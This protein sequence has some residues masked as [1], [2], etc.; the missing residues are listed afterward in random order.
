MEA[1]T[2]L[3]SAS[4][5]LAADS[6]LRMSARSKRAVLRSV[7]DRISVISMHLANDVYTFLLIYIH[8]AGS[9]KAYGQVR[10]CALTSDSGTAIAASR[11]P[12]P[13][14]PHPRESSRFRPSACAPASL[15]KR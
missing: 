8:V 11:T 4:W 3:N 14:H 10:D 7:R 15:V 13:P 9:Y 6:R 1:A 5:R 12:R 2:P